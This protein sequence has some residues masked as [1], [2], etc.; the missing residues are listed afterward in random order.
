MKRVSL[1]FFAFM[2][3]YGTMTAQC[4]S[5]GPNANHKD[6]DVVDI[7]IGS[8]IHTTLVAAVK[9]VD[10][11]HTLKGEG[12]FTIFA[13]TD[14]A[15]A[16]LPEGTLGELLKPE[17][18]HTL[19]SILTYHVVP[20][21]LMASDVVHAVKEGGGK[22]TVTSVQGHEITVLE[23]GG[24]IWLKDQQ[25]GMAKITATDLSGSNGV[26]HVIDKVIMP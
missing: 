22:V 3:A 19:T 14:A 21:R 2:L 7:A 18:K 10:L 13:P 12:P 1:I 23:K 6:Q 24:S 16:K 11:V 20:A 5:N 15:F 25:G 17:N 4:K 9:A 8:D 26:V